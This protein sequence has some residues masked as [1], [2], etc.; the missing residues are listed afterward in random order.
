MINYWEYLVLNIVINV[1]TTVGS[2]FFRLGQ[3]P[4]IDG[5]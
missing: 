4:W 5:I 2:T 3:A 1:I